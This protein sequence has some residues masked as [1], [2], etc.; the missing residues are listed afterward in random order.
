MS[1]ILQERQTCQ[2]APKSYSVSAQRNLGGQMAMSISNFLQSCADTV[3]YGKEVD[4]LQIYERGIFL[5]LVYMRRVND[6]FFS[7]FSPYIIN[8]V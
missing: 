2:I 5:V 4:A 6:V 7:F 8:N 1:N 3:R